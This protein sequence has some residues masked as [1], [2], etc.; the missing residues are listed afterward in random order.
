MEFVSAPGQE[1]RGR[2]WGWDG[3]RVPRHLLARASP[4]D[5]CLSNQRLP[6]DRGMVFPKS[7]TILPQLAVFRCR[8]ERVW[9]VLQ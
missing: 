6:C 8:E 3:M 9:A 7:G 1:L 4:P 5:Q 2:F